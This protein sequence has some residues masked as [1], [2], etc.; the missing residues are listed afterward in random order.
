MHVIFSLSLLLGFF[1]SLSLLSSSS[2]V[3]REY[4]EIY[5]FFENVVD[6]QSQAGSSS[7]RGRL[8]V[9]ADSH[10]NKTPLLFLS[11]SLLPL[12]HFLKMNI[13]VFVGRF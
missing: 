6:N 2:G 12:L 13:V 3:Y 7:C 8:D 5:L 1:L 9:P 11:L 10:T 4:K